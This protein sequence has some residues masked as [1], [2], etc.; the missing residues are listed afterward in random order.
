MSQTRTSKPGY[1]SDCCCSD[2]G[3]A[4]TAA[5]CVDRPPKP[6]TRNLTYPRNRLCV[7]LRVRVFVR[8]WARALA[9]VRV[10]VLLRV[11]ARAHV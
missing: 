4:K 3:E 2:S 9:C 8:V 1:N 11:C 10:Y 6:L 5:C 7:C